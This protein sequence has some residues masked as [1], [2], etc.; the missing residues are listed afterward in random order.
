[1]NVFLLLKAIKSSIVQPYSRKEKEVTV[2]EAEMG[3]V[4]DGYGTIKIKGGI[5]L[6][7]KR[8]ERTEMLLSNV[9]YHTNVIISLFQSLG[10]LLISSRRLNR[11]SGYAGRIWLHLESL[12]LVMNLLTK[13]IG[14]GIMSVKQITLTLI[15][16]MYEV[17]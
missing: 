15:V 3:T 4:K 14:I 13:L 2:I 6:S 8:V 10:N 11:L 7:A 12:V 16:L 17:G 5:T 9:R 1:M